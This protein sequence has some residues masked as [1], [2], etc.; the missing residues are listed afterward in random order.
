MRPI[1]HN[2]EDD[3]FLPGQD[4]RFARPAPTRRAAAIA[5]GLRAVGVEPPPDYQEVPEGES[6]AMRV[7]ADAVIARLWGVRDP[8]DPT[9]WRVAPKSPWRRFVSASLLP[10]D[11]NRYSEGRGGSATGV[12]PTI[13]IAGPSAQIQAFDLRSDHAAVTPPG[14]ITWSASAAVTPR[15]TIALATVSNEKLRDYFLVD[16]FSAKGDL[17]KLRSMIN[18]AV[19]NE[20]ADALNRRS[21][22]QFINAT[23]TAPVDP[24]TG[25]VSFTGI[26]VQP[27]T[28]VPYIDDAITAVE[29]LRVLKRP[30]SVIFIPWALAK[31]WRLAKNST[32]GY[33]FDPAQ[34]MSIDGVPVVG[35]DGIAAGTSTFFLVGDFSWVTAL[36]RLMPNG[37]LVSVAV[38]GEAV[39]GG[40][41]DFA[42]D[43]TTFRLIERWDQN[44]SPGYGPSIVKV[45]GVNAL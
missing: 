5:A 16:R 4:P 3:P 40:A 36:W 37:R 39:I 35:H 19:P 28:S 32:G 25:V 6:A 34:P 44:L 1:L 12:D 2:L 22:D 10:E 30:P 43:S 27:S 13:S 38:S 23:A 15:E 18:P 26:T 7:L 9:R 11:V 17:V 14:D 33:L 24:R 8:D 45:T 20:L 21:N 42:D 29:N 41:S 31:Y